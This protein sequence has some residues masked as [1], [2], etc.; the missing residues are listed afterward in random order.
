MEVVVR[1]RAWFVKD[2]WRL[3]LIAIA[4]LM[5]DR[6][7]FA[8]D[9][10]V[11]AW[12]QAEYL[13]A[14]LTYRQAIAEGL[15]SW[16][17][18]SGEWWTDFWQLSPKTPP[19]V[20]I[21]TVPFLWILGDGIDGA[22]MVNALSGLVI[23]G[24]VYAIA[25]TVF[26]RPVGSRLGLWGAGLCWLLPGLWRVRLDY[27]LDFPLVAA[28]MVTLVAVLRW[29]WSGRGWRMFGVEVQRPRWFDFARVR[30]RGTWGWAIASGVCFGL[31]LLVKQ[32]AV[33]FLIVPWV[34]IGVEAIWRRRWLRLT[35]WLAAFFVSVPIWGPWY[36]TNWLLI[37]SG[38]KRATIDSARIEGDPGLNTLDAW[39]HYLKLLP[40][41]CSL[42]L[43]W[44]VLGGAMLAMVRWLIGWRFLP[45]RASSEN[46]DSGA[47]IQRAAIAK[48]WQW[49]WIVL[50]G[51]YL[52]CS[53]LVNKDWRYVLPYLPILSLV[54]AQGLLFWKG[55]WGVRTRWVTVVLT[56]GLLTVNSFAISPAG[57]VAR[58]L[59][60]V[61]M[62]R[63]LQLAY[64]GKPWPHS[65]AIAQIQGREP[66][67]E[68]T[69][70]VLPST[71][72]I[73]QHNVNYFG[74]IA[75]FQVYGRQVGV[76][77][78]FVAADGRSLDWFL[79]KSG[80]QGSL[81]RQSK[82]EAQAALVETVKN[83]GD[84]KKIATW[85]LPDES[86]LF[87]YGRQPLSSEITPIKPMPTD[88]M[89]STNSTSTSRSISRSIQSVR[90]AQVTVPE[91]V[92]PG[93]PFAVTYDWEG[94]WK[95][96]KNG[97]I[98]LTWTAVQSGAES[99]VRTRWIDDR[100]IAQGN[101]FGE[102]QGWFR[103]SDRTAT[104]PPPNL[105]PGPYRVQA[106]YLDS[107]TGKTYPLQVPNTTVTIDPAAVPQP[108]PELDRV[109]Q[110][111]LLALRLRQGLPEFDGVFAEIGRINQYDPHQI[112]TRQAAALARQRLKTEPD[113]LSHWYLLG[114][115]EVL[116][117][118]G[119]EAIDAFTAI[120]RLD[121]NNPYAHAYLAF[122]N[123]YEFRA[124]A[125]EV[126]IEN[127]LVRSPDQP[128]FH[129][130]RAVARLLKLNLWGTWEDLHQ[131]L[132]VLALGGNRTALG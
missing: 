71:A 19:L 121:E 130:I 98:S 44:V 12:D 122:V 99:E 73:N 83:G 26:P 16:G 106:T 39:I 88:S 97:L 25:T 45:Q 34:W 74:A 38:G 72:E 108:A 8:V 84:F 58:Q 11:P 59:G 46:T 32:T 76:D 13:T 80:N 93:V 70:G 56:I 53:A 63:S 124:G 103:V 120:A 67:R 114:L 94:P 3:L 115:A 111:R 95:A 31:A 60:Q 6:L 101:L 64:T 61:M 9:Q 87:L 37:L 51:S 132:S 52:L 2:G 1:S 123:L 23:T 54:L 47:L 65:E 107:Q 68:V 75:D 29:H 24:S 96:L 50:G 86:E 105:A 7:W 57:G 41:H 89:D 129:L 33:F 82:R 10:S 100:A 30:S 40:Q 90:L 113:R 79:T 66:Y 43:L 91:R 62:P 125:A 42:L 104:L 20:A 18:L 131:G 27:L 28:V 128:E 14:A 69:V 21:A 102:H 17:W 35:Q 22:T 116:Q 127:A 85:L 112:Y 126:A 81:R 36:R 55:F 92:P 109:T 77:P 48:G 15:S 49:I 117:R 118:N 78:N 110:L 5:F 119:P 4:G